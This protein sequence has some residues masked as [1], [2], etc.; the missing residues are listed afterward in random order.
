M[1]ETFYAINQPPISGLQQVWLEPVG[2]LSSADFP[3]YSAQLKPC[4]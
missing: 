1:G 2:A 3:T 4:Q